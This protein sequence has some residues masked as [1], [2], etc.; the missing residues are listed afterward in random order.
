[1]VML[2]IK[3]DFQGVQNRLNQISADLQKRVIPAALNK[4]IAKA[5][6]S[7]VREITS[8]Y[9]IKAVDV[10]ARLRVIRATK[11]FKK[12][13]AI[14]DPFAGGKRG[15][16][17]NVIK[18]AEKKITLA[19]GRRRAKAGTADQLRFQIKKIG[20]KK[21]I[22][23]AFIGNKGRTIFERTGDA[24]LPIKPVTTIDVPQMFNTRRINA[25]VVKRI[26]DEL[27]IEFDRA[28]RAAMTGSI[29]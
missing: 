28:I 13:K 4:T 24:R 19:E 18:F 8:T 20:G 12:W 27:A 15:R 21:T 22:Q 10:R 25:V 29:R 2:T 5:N 23:G 9:N 6:T 17:L 7:M 1:M 16:A 14:L 3:T 26:N 11:D